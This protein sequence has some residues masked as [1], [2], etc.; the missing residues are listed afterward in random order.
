MSQP[1][2]PTKPI[3]PIRQIE[4]TQEDI[5]D[6]LK[7]LVMRP[8]LELLYE[9]DP[10]LEQQFGPSDIAVT[11]YKLTNFNMEIYPEC[12]PINDYSLEYPVTPADNQAF[13]TICEQVMTII[14]AKIK[15]LTNIDCSQNQDKKYLH[16]GNTKCIGM[17]FRYY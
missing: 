2:K 4:A 9:H 14:Y 1:T 17:K 5:K 6:F 13:C 7:L 11:T 15:E 8:I 12:I 3:K 10:N 16:L